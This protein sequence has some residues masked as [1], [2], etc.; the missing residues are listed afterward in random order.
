MVT[1]TSFL[2]NL[3]SVAGNEIIQVT[4]ASAVQQY[5][6]LF[7]EYVTSGDWTLCSCVGMPLIIFLVSKLMS[8][9]PYKERFI[10]LLLAAWIVKL[11]SSDIYLFVMEYLTPVGSAQL[12]SP[13]MSS[14]GFTA[15]EINA[16][17]TQV[18]NESGLSSEQIQKFKPHLM[19]HLRR[20]DGNEISQV[21]EIPIFKILVLSYWPRRVVGSVSLNHLLSGWRKELLDFFF[22]CLR[23]ITL[24][25]VWKQNP[26]FS[27]MDVM[28][29]SYPF[30]RLFNILIRGRQFSG[31]KAEL[32]ELLNNCLALFIVEIFLLLLYGKFENATQQIWWLIFV[33]CAWQLF[34]RPPLDGFGNEG[35]EI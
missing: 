3:S 32:K 33:F 17:F 29:L 27:S 30:S 20:F 13:I 19:E 11:C 6:K 7:F 15:E 16:V 12:A 14:F 1:P 24:H 31:W 9:R 25:I 4:Q 35:D 22:Y 8:E 23:M 5:K 26:Q 18:L 34:D 28:T 21:S 10:V 2:K